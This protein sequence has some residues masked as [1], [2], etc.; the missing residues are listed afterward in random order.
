MT[1]LHLHDVYT[2][3][4]FVSFVLISFFLFPLVY[5]ILF[6]L[7]DLTLTL[8]DMLWRSFDMTSTCMTWRWLCMTCY[9]AHLTWR[10]FAWLNLDFA[11]HFY[12]FDVTHFLLSIVSV[13]CFFPLSLVLS[14]IVCSLF[15]VLI[16]LPLFLSFPST[17]TDCSF[18]LKIFFSCSFDTYKTQYP[19]PP[20]LLPR[21]PIQTNRPRLMIAKIYFSPLMAISWHLFYY[22]W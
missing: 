12:H 19:T 15:S 4:Y 7:H 18:V 10:P 14:T 21:I 5:F 6:T 22:R 17:T 20:A 16:I 2:F 8:H 1:T 3:S 9:D 13:L 11:C